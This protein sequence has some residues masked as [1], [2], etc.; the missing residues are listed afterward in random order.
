MKKLNEKVLSLQNLGYLWLEYFLIFLCAPVGMALLVK[1]TP[2]PFILL[3][4]MIAFYLLYND[5][6]FDKK[7]FY[8]LPPLTLEYARILIQ[9]VLFA[10]LLYY[11]IAHFTP[12]YLFF[13]IRKDIFLWVNI[14]LIYTF[15]AVYPQEIIYRALIF[16]RYAPLVKEEKGLI[17]LSAFAFAFG[18][19]IYLNPFSVLLSLLGGYIFSFTY[20]RT[21]SLPLVYLEHLLYGLILY[22]IG[23]GNYFYSGFAG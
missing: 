16:H 5:E 3:G 10:G 12:K 15:L 21:R 7:I 11:F 8:R 19:V 9:V 14:I 1:V 23:F 4:G 13:F 22:T 18:H 6:H 20:V 2:L 17:H